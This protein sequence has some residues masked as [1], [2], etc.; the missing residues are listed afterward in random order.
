M[1][2]QTSIAVIQVLNLR[3][4]ICWKVLEES[5]R[6]TWLQ[7]QALFTKQKGAILNYVFINLFS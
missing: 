6:E 4:M 1:F 3:K 2:I 5:E 7:E